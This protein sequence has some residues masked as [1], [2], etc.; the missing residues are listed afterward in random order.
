MDCLRGVR[1]LVALFVVALVLAGCAADPGGPLPSSAET[2]GENAGSAAA[3][4]NPGADCPVTTPVTATPPDSQYRSPLQ[5]GKYYVSADEKLWVRAWDWRKG[6]EKYPWVKPF[7][8]ELVV[9]GRRLDS[10]APPLWAEIAP[11]YSRDFQPSFINIPTAGCWEIEARAGTSALRLVVYIPSQP[12]IAQDLDCA[13]FGDV[14]KPDRIIVVGRIMS[15]SV[16]P[17]GRWAWLS[18][19]VMDN[20]Y[21]RSFNGSAASAGRGVTVLQDAEREPLLT[22]GEDY[23]LVL[24]GVP[25]QIVCPLQTV[26]QVDSSQDPAPVVSL[27]A[28]PL[29]HGK[30]VAAIEAEIR[31]AQR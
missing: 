4:A 10:E 9:Q 15:R 29:W 22:Q 14:V 1:W 25:W 13:Q 28:Q 17:N 6:R 5:H 16:G 2:G 19:R 26:A 24:R 8:S 3:A 21:A 11:N 27:A 12:L 31:N 7:G 18:V 30:T 20:L 23:L